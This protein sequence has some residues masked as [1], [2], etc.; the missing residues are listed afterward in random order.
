MERDI[1]WTELKVSVLWWLPLNRIVL[2][3]LFWT[4][5]ILIRYFRLSFDQE[6]KYRVRSNLVNL[7][8]PRKLWWESETAEL[9]TSFCHII[10]NKQFALVALIFLTHFRSSDNTLKELFLKVS[11][12]SCTHNLNKLKRGFPWD[13][14]RINKLQ[15]LKRSIDFSD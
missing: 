8:I 2:N 7:T 5:T 13:L 3:N 4:L 14:R 15:E 10:F 1:I 11:S 12:Y 6:I 9:K